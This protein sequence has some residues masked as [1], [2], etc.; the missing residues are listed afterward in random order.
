MPT[1]ESLWFIKVSKLDQVVSNHGLRLG[2]SEDKWRNYHISLQV[3]GRFMKNKTLQWYVKKS[4]T[5]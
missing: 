5:Y 2:F 1:F 3:N 4:E